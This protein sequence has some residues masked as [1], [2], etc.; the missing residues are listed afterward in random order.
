[1][2]GHTRPVPRELYVAFGFLF[3]VLV[4]GGTV[5]IVDLSG[6]HEVQCEEVHDVPGFSVRPAE[7]TGE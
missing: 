7:V 1:M 5:E 4:G 2:D 3:G 6:V